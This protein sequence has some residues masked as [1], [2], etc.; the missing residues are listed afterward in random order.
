MDT[1]SRRD[2]E[3]R[4][5]SRRKTSFTAGIPPGF[6]L[7]RRDSRLP[8]N[9]SRRD[10]EDRP[11][12]TEFRRDEISS[13]GIRNSADRRPGWGF[14]PRGQCPLEKVDPG[15]IP[16]GMNLIPAGFPPIFFH[17]GGMRFIPPGIPPGSNGGIPGGFEV[18]PG[19]IPASFVINFRLVSFLR[20]FS[21]Q[22][23]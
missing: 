15:G 13:T 12:Q 7:F 17:S 2:S 23:N 4:R 14:P 21:C 5:E 20:N 18:G 19:G 6:A 9:S 10:S 3:F 16:A 1:P 8:K 22:S 11:G